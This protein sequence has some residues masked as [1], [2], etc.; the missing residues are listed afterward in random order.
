VTKNPA[1]FDFDFE[2]KAQNQLFIALFSPSTLNDIFWSR[3][4][5]T[6][7]KGTDRLN[8]FQFSKRAS[9]ELKIASAKCLN[10]RYRFAPYLEKLK[11]K[12][13]KALPRVIGIPT[14]RD[15][16]VLKQLNAF[17]A[18]I[19][20]DRVPKNIANGYVRQITADLKAAANYK[21][22]VC[23]TDIKQFYDTVKRERLINIL[24]RGIHCKPALRLIT[25]ALATPIVPKNTHRSRH[26]DFQNDK[27]GI[28]Q[29]LAISNILASIY[30]KDVDEPMRKLNVKYWRYVDDVLIYGKELEVLSAYNS[31]KSRLRIRGLSRC[32]QER[33]I[34]SHCR[35]HS[36]IWDTG[37]TGR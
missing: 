34:S 32:T 31:L 37:S 36:A 6:T 3:F 21:T 28:P 12:G 29:G 24:R 5:T 25:H 14:V 19:Y 13:H 22:F 15:R 11:T 9:A 2:A 27:R 35:Y 33:L 30:M 20:P 8:G 17:I 18:A 10:G 1:Q 16:I 4:A 23:S 26:K 7:G